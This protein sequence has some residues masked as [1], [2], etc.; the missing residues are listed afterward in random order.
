MYKVATE[1]KQKKMYKRNEDGGRR[2]TRRMSSELPRA[3]NTDVDN[4]NTRRLA[5]TGTTDMMVV[6]CTYTTRMAAGRA[7]PTTNH[8]HNNNPL[9]LSP[10]FQHT[11]THIHTSDK[12]NTIKQ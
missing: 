4:K 6:Q 10:I 3:K 8:T 5:A 1:K 2:R 7:L 12:Y 11:H 9:S